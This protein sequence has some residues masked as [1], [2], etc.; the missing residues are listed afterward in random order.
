MKKTT[1]GNSE[2]VSSLKNP[3]FS[4]NLSCSIVIRAYNEEQH[5]GRL[6]TGIMKQTVKD[7]EIILV[8]S[9]STD[10]TVSIAARFPVKIVH[11]RPET[12]TFGYSLNKGIAASSKELIIIASAHVHPVY[13]DWIEQ[14]L[15][16]FEDSQ[17]GITYGK[18]RGAETTQFSEHQVFAR[19]YSETSQHRQTHPFCNNANAAIRQSL[20]EQRPYDEMLTGLEDLEWAKW[21]IDQGFS[22]AYVAEAEVTHV[23]NETPRQVY[24]RYRREAMA[25]KRIF[26][27]ENF[28][29]LHFLHLMTTN[30]FSDLWHAARQNI[31]FNQW[32]NI[33]WFRLMQFWG[34]YQGYRQASTLL[35]KELRQTFY[36][37]NTLQSLPAQKDR[38]VEPIR[39]QNT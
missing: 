39:Y 35:N 31:V 6:L 24:N 10:A 7:K 28:T 23:H 26:P 25:L 36:Y 13:P 18:Q 27:K 5:I 8:D 16:P 20:W 30:T 4:E 12:F 22:I 32:K 19:W 9:G 21:V 34:T 38:N 15:K 2:S 14:L 3:H 29:F 17:I 11:I 1:T 33:F 37:P